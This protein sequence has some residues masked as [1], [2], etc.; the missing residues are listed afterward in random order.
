[1]KNASTFLALC[2]ILKSETLLIVVF[3]PRSDNNLHSLGIIC[4]L[5]VNPEI[6]EEQV[7]ELIASSRYSNHVNASGDSWSDFGR[8]S[9]ILIN[10]LKEHSL[11]LT[12]VLDLSHE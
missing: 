12:I 3:L 8:F 11:F 1:M 6:K 5:Y 9:E 7:K 2:L 10:A 4:Y